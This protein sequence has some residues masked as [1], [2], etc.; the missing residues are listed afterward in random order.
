MM[1]M[2]GKIILTLLQ[3]WQ[4]EERL[5]KGGEPDMHTCAKM[6]LYD[7]QRGKLPWFEAPP[8]MNEGTEAEGEVDANLQV[9]QI[10]S[11]IN[12]RSDYVDEAEPGTHEDDQEEDADETEVKE[13]ENESEETEQAE[14]AAPV[15]WDEIYQSV[16]GEEV[17][18]VPTEVGQQKKRKR[19]K[20]EKPAEDPPAKAKVVR[21]KKK[22]AKVVQEEEEEKPK[23]RR[24]SVRKQK[25]GVHFYDTHNVKNR[26]RSKKRKSAD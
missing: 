19:E 17:D 25:A 18:T 2:T 8:M 24:E 14:S 23:K 4:R 12:V 1:W 5:L 22:K 20:S 7:W 11:K 21:K 16:V 6:I 3:R 10:F 15:D 13:E 26:N 9:K